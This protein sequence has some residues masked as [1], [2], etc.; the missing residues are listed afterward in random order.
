[1]NNSTVNPYTSHW[2][3]S[4]G[5]S[6]AFAATLSVIT[7]AAFIGNVLVTVTFLKTAKLRTSSNYFIVNMAMS[8][9]VSACFTW[10]LFAIEGML[11]GASL[12]TNPSFVV[13]VCKLAMYARGVSQMVSILSL[14]LVAADRFRAIVFPL[15]GPYFTRKTRTTCLLITWLVP[16]ASCFP[17]INFST[18]VMVNH[19]TFCRF[20]M[21]RVG[22]T[23][24]YA[25]GFFG[26]YIVPSFVVI[27]LYSLIMRSLRRKSTLIQRGA[28]KKREKQNKRILIISILI[29][30]AFFICWTP[31]CVYLSLKML[32]PSLFVQ[33][34]CN[35]LV[36]LFFYVFPS[37]SMAIN[38]AI[39]FTYG[40][41]FR[42]ALKKQGTQPCS[43]LKCTFRRSPRNCGVG[44]DECLSPKTFQ[45]SPKLTSDTKKHL[46]IA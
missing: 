16:L 29:V 44:K 12:I 19:Q 15:K 6:V 1:M 26:L 11:N 23:I 34:K 4:Y 30:S 40:T 42:Q 31:L 5:V 2:A 32:Y 28:S 36:G 3:R 17:Y 20:T 7:A 37:L 18:I 43:V 14:L 24:F 41:N 8:D 22:T 45:S 38:P 46:T 25:V 27:I 21:N 9:L 10:P 39:L 13:P 33:D 35:V